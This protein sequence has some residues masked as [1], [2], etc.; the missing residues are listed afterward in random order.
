[1]RYGF[2]GDTGLKVSK[3]CLGTMTFGE[4][5]GEA[6]A[7]AQLD[8][9][10]AQGINVIDTAEIYPSPPGEATFGA[11]ER[12]IGNWLKSRG[13]R[14][15]VVL[16]TKV[17]GRSKMGWPR[18]WGGGTRL[19]ADNIEAALD[20]SLRRLQ[21]DYIDL[22][23]LHWPERRT[24]I[25]GQLGYKPSRDDDAIPL[26][27]TLAALGRLVEKG[28]I[29]Y[30][31]VCNETPWGLMTCLRL[32]G[33]G[34]LPRV[35]SIQNNYSLLDRSF[36]IGLAEV[37]HRE[38]L[39]MMAYA[40]LAMGLLTGKYGGGRKPA[41]AR[42]TEYPHF[43]RYTT[44]RGLQA[45]EEYVALARQYGL[46]PARMALAY[47][48]SRPFITTAILG[49]SSLAQL[50]SNIESIELELDEP[51]LTAIEAIHSRNPNPCP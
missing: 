41:G 39:G 16:A 42:L 17:A 33:Q 5:C 15:Q 43:S 32:A 37:V 35:A 50:Q 31:G 6:D 29:R 48:A 36:E 46:E 45:A 44:E 40:P 9:G 8:H 23:Q 28:K 19:D 12:I 25:F 21:T 14:A 22:Y 27:E 10:L 20:G 38:R 13:V 49:A 30:I 47:V 24:N 7:H 34:G 26:A 18:P 1:M 11:T 51:L 3:L 2:L 4:Q